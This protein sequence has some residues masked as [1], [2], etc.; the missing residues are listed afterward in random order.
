[1]SQMGGIIE[2][3]DR[4]DRIMN[5]L[6]YMCMQLSFAEGTFSD[7]FDIRHFR[8]SSDANNILRYPQQVRCVI[9]KWEFPCGNPRK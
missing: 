1:M 7:T 9:C 5:L 8:P 4:R 2:I 3:R 6:L